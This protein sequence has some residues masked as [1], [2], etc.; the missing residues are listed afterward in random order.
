MVQGAHGAGRRQGSLPLPRHIGAFPVLAEAINDDS[1]PIREDC[2]DYYPDTRA[3]WFLQK[4]SCSVR[5]VKECSLP[6]ADPGARQ[7]WCFAINSRT[8][9]TRS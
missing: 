4:K 9:E 6:G 3:L 5:S 7:S 2:L 8:C 1:R